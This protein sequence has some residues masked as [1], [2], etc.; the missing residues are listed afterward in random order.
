MAIDSLPKQMLSGNQSRLTHTVAGPHRTYTGFPLAFTCQ[1]SNE[2]PEVNTFFLRIRFSKDNLAARTI[3][4]I[5]REQI[6]A[7]QV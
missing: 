4:I 7:I 1:S 5:I 3:I 6:P 2:H